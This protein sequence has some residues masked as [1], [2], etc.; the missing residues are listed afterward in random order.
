MAKKRMFNLDVVETDK[1]L[2]MPYMAQLLY[3]H[4]GMKADDDGFIASPK[5]IA[6]MIGAT[7]KDISTLIDN[8]YLIQ[9]DSGIVVIT[10]WRQNNTLKSDRYFETNFL[11]ER[12][13]LD[14]SKNKVYYLK[15]GLEPFWNHFGNTDKIR[16]DKNSIDKINI[17]NNNNI[18][19][20]TNN[21]SVEDY[22][23]IDNYL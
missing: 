5:R 3:F 20:S 12:G 18:T 19:P 1:F 13:L 16:E 4:L 11:E 9:F 8:E 2:D 10:H 21:I 14:I 22:D 7:D 6:L 17:N 23:Y 15:K